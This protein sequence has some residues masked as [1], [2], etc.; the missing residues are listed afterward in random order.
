MMAL[1][2]PFFPI[3]PVHLSVFCNALAAPCSDVALMYDF[4]MSASQSS[5]LYI[6][7]LRDCLPWAMIM[8]FVI[9]AVGDQLCLLYI[10]VAIPC[11][12]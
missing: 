12:A 6:A 1:F 5:L 7:L 2:A 11:R 4:V 9:L 8:L 10:A 3:K